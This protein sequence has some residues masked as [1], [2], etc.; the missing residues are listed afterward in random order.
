MRTRIKVADLTLS[1]W[2]YL[3]TQVP[4][5]GRTFLPGMPRACV[6]F[7]LTPDFSSL[8]IEMDLVELAGLMV[9]LAGMDLKRLAEVALSETTGEIPTVSPR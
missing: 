6:E 1:Q 3:T 8:H 4:V 7:E 9:V 2:D 5:N